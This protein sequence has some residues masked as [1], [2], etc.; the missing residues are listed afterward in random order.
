VGGLDFLDP[1]RRIA[2]Q[3]GLVFHPHPRNTMRAKLSQPER[4]IPGQFL[5]L[6]FPARV[7]I[8]ISLEEEALFV[9][10]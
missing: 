2:S 5:L 9:F 10:S 4:W 6:P 1:L 3:R 8:W 7:S